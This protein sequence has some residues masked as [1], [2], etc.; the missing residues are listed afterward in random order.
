ML[1]AAGAA[2]VAAVGVAMQQ[3]ANWADE[4][5]R[6]RDTTGLS[7]D[8]LQKLG[9]VGTQTGA[10]MDAMATA[11]KR[12]QKSLGDVM[13]GEGAQQA[14]AFAQ[15][16]LDPQT[17]AKMSPEKAFLEVIDV[18]RRVEGEARQA[19]FATG[20]MGKSAQAMAPMFR[21]TREEL[22]RMFDDAGRSVISDADVAAADRYGDAVEAI[23]KRYESLRAQLVIPLMDTL[24]PELEKLSAFLSS[25]EG[26]E[27][28]KAFAEG[29]AAMGEALVAIMPVVKALSSMF[30]QG[31]QFFK[32]V[33]G[34]GTAV[35]MGKPSQAMPEATRALTSAGDFAPFFQAIPGAGGAGAAAGLLGQIFTVLNTRLPGATGG[36]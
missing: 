35:G 1:A 16:R 6:L 5:M 11:A 12:L 28:V 32:D 27:Q 19:S 22:E 21:M 17:L 3:T 15:L 33:S 18:I 14:K 2:G 36:Q 8:T 34:A 29:F 24:A 31:Q 26:K 23:Q 25:N 13:R 4:L 20:L 10:G 7:L 9:F 30:V